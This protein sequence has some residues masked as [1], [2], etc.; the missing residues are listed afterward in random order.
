MP[1]TNPS[2]IPEFTRQ[3]KRQPKLRKPR[4]TR[5]LATE[6]SRARILRNVHWGN[7]YRG[8]DQDVARRLPKHLSDEDFHALSCALSTV[9]GFSLLWPE[10]T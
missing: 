2:T 5:C 3:L 7:R 1:V 9:S 4:R 6:G 10:Y 8:H